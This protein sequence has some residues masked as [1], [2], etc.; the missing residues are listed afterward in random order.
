MLRVYTCS[1][2][3]CGHC[4]YRCIYLYRDV[5][6]LLGE[7]VAALLGR[8]PLVLQRLHVPLHA[9]LVLLHMPHPFNPYIIRPPCSS[10]LITAPPGCQAVCESELHRIF[11]NVKPHE[12]VW[13]DNVCYLEDGDLGLK[14]RDGAA[15]RRGLRGTGLNAQSHTDERR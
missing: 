2:A 3:E 10:T 6:T 7:C 13:R 8:G 4:V 1:R 9:G 11:S 5:R 15:E 14:L 12:N